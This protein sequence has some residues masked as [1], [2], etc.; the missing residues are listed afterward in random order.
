MQL[1]ST[2]SD[3]TGPA[4]PASSPPR[5]QFA[6]AS[7]PGFG[8]PFNTWAWSMAWWQGKLY[9]GTN[10]AWFCCEQAAKNI[11]L[12]K[13]LPLR[14]PGLVQA[15]VKYPPDD[16]AVTCT[17]DPRDLPLRAEIW[18]WSPETDLWERVY[19]APEDA[20]VRGRTDRHVS[21]EVGYRYMLPVTEP[22]GTEAL[23]V[24]SVTP[25]FVFWLYGKGGHTF[26][27][28][29]LLRTTD[30]VNFTR[31]P[32][33]PGTFM[34]ELPRNTLRTMV[35]YG[36]K[37]FVTHGPARGYGFLMVSDDP[38]AGNDTF[39]LAAPESFKVFDMIE[40]NDHLYLGVRDE[41][42]GYAVVK[43]NA[44]GEPPFQFTPVLRR[45]A[46]LAKPSTNVISMR[47][48]R[49]R[50]YV[51]TD[52]PAEIVRINPD[53]SWDLILGTPRRT[54]DG[55]RYP[56][57]GFDAG[58]NNYLNGHIWWMREYEGRLYL[59]TMNMGMVLRTLPDAEELLM[60]AAGVSVYETDDGAHFYPVT[61]DGFGKPTNFGLR[62]MVGTEHGL[63][64]GT[65]NNWTGL[66][67]WRG[68]PVSADDPAHPAPPERTEVEMTA[69]G[70]L[71]TWEPA[72]GAV[73]YHVF[74]AA[75]HDRRGT[76]ERN[77]MLANILRLVRRFLQR[78]GM[79]L[80]VLPD[81]VWIP[82]H[83]QAVAIVSEPRYRD[84][85]ASLD[86]HYMYY[87]VAEN[88]QGIRSVPGNVVT[89][90]SF[91]PAVTFASVSSM[92]GGSAGRLGPLAAGAQARLTDAAADA[93]LAR[94]ADA[95]ESL[96]ALEGSLAADRETAA[97]P[98]AVDDCLL[99]LRRLERRVALAAAGLVPAGALLGVD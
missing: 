45:G 4:I 23:Y 86:G 10:R 38:A 20:V 81:R 78:T 16:P 31:V 98:W 90:P 82:E 3:T 18:R 6:P 35:S 5:L 64:L 15:L 66:E 73:T 24:A 74:R 11:G 91:A 41:E 75:F 83:F 43:T 87:V 99:A 32:Q 8:D 27:P 50:L 25:K 60:P 39:R 40:Y 71:L 59:G 56:L 37:L 2:L 12:S 96:R 42:G 54:P 9:V 17:P 48:F 36:G 1:S 85:D 95:T 21:R 13:K 55:W 65:A 57:S 62:T 34:G 28:P 89:A 49:G 94:W 68:T 22:D 70:S 72:P 53:D 52:R 58:F 33:D 19:Q 61:L 76:I 67:I 47:V 29:G 26:P 97:S 30:G 14:I 7:Q 88:E 51:G 93:R 77:R 63:F 80:P 79:Y 92:L 69:T 46:Y 44:A 84:E